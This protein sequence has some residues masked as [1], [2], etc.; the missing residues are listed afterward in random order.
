VV[1]CGGAVGRVGY[2][3]GALMSALY[4]L[5][6]LFFVLAVGLAYIKLKQ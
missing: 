5:P 1:H 3:G 6:L 4:E 2:P